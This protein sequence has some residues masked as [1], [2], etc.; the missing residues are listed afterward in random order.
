MVNIFGI[1][2]ELKLIIVPII[3]VLIG[4]IAFKILKKLVIKVLEKKNLKAAQKQRIK[5]LIVLIVNIIKYLTIICVLLAILS[6]WGVNVKSIVAGLGIGTA[7]IGLA[8]KDL[9]TDLIAGFSI[10]AEG[11]YE[12]GD[13]IEVDGFMGEVIFIGLRTTRIR[14]FKGATKIIANHYMDNIVNY[15]EHNSLAVIDVSIAYECDETLIEKTFNKIF[16]DLNG[17]IPHAIGELELWGVNELSDSA[18][19]YRVVVETEPMQQYAVQRFLRKELKKG[20]DAAKIKIP[21]QQIEVH[22]GK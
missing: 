8:F 21:Y 4:I 3:Y 20:L 11:E 9:A 2:L 16:K 19:V 15:S 13:T 12:I 17:K 1:E 22:N 18:V 10:I 6:V 14:D 5:T 7:V